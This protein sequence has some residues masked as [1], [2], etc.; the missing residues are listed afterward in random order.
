MSAFLTN[1]YDF[2]I[3]KKKCEAKWK[4]I[5][6]PFIDERSAHT[7]RD[8]YSLLLKQLYIPPSFSTMSEASILGFRREIF[9]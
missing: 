4:Q 3:D 6:Y 9:A 2:H 5:F 8:F 7:L 1:P